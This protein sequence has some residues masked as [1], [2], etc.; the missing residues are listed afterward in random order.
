MA[1]AVTSMRVPWVAN[2]GR[3][4]VTM[5]AATLPVRICWPRILT[6]SRSSIAC[7][8]CLVKGALLSVSPV[9]LSPTTS[10]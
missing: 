10:P 3:S 5:T 2:G 6:P 8:D 1:E 4:A 9:P 7:S